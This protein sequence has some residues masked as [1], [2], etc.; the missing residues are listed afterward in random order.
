[1]FRIIQWFK[2][3]WRGYPVFGSAARSPQ[4]ERVR[5]EWLKSHPQCAVTGDTKGCEVHHKKPFHLHP[6]LELD[7][8]NFITLRRDMHLLY[9]HLMNWS[10]FNDSVE[11]DTKLWY[12]KIQNRKVA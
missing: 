5:K 10:A 2:D 6:E 11:E 1:M 12:S 9:G 8:S 4:W 3:L 7:P